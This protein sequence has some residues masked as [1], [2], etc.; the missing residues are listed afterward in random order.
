MKLY[1]VQAAS[2]RLREL[3]R[4]K[5]LVDKVGAFLQLEIVVDGFIATIN[6]VN[7]FQFRIILLQKPRGQFASGH[8]SEHLTL[9]QQ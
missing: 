5:R 6:K 9:S 7:H 8:S 1:F 2:D 4:C 3:M